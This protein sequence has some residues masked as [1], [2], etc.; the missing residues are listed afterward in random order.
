MLLSKKQNIQN[1]E[2]RW[3]T[4]DIEKFQKTINKLT[5]DIFDAVLNI[6]DSKRELALVFS[7]SAFQFQKVLYKSACLDEDD[8]SKS[9]LFIY[10]D[11]EVGPAGNVMNS[12]WDKLLSVNTL[13][14]K[15]NYK[16]K[17]D[18]WNTLTTDGVSFWKRFKVA[19]YETIVYRLAIKFMKMM[20]NWFFKKELLLPNENELNIEIASSMALRG[21]KITKIQPEH[22]F[23][24]GDV[25]ADVDIALI[26]E[27][28]LP[29]M[30][31]RVE[32][33]VTPSAVKV[34]ME[35]FK[36][37]LEKKL[38]QFTLLVS[39]WEKA[40]VSNSKIKQT[41]LMNAPGNINGYALAYVCRKRNI[42]LISSQHGVTVEISKAH[43]MMQ[44]NFDN[45]V[46][47]IVLSYN[48]TIVDIEKNTYFDKSKHYVV[49]MPLRL[50]RM[51]H[52]EI[53]NK[54]T[55]PIVYVSSNTYM[56]FSVSQRTD[57]INAKAEQKII[58]EVLG[59][60]PHKV[61]YKTYPLDNRR[62]SD[63]DPVLN[64]IE[65]SN[66]IEVFSDKVDMRYLISEHRI[67]ITSQATSTL[68]WLVILCSEIK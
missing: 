65:G 60:L 45:S 8:F 44:V 56:G 67:T 31:K 46:A 11:G 29:I 43:S 40:I 19:G 7:K 4:K 15:I 28:I 9:R 41:V 5:K 59:K 37:F 39:G 66:N 16:L 68:G 62:S 26:Y 24:S 32:N 2:S 13:F 3:S 34:T 33:W 35:L 57:Y 55:P 38:D 58:T 25:L 53:V 12:P 50:I 23:K 52:S 51:N 21:V 6:D 42:P 18:E 49:G 30:Y 27:A 10:V 17:N 63:V 47:D 36:L 20:P 54:Y 1:I 48:S 61:R 14:S 22:L 64:S